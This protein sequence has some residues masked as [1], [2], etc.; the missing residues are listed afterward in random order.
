MKCVFCGY[1]STEKELL[2][3]CTGCIMA[4]ICRKVK[5]INCGY[6]AYSEPRYLKRIREWRRE[7]NDESGNDRK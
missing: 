7:R 4:G 2:T 1:V 3:A 6:E 5:C